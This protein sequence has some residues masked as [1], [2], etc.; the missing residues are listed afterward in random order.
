MDQGEVRRAIFNIYGADECRLRVD[1]LASGRV[2][3]RLRTGRGTHDWTCETLEEL[4]W[5]A[6][7]ADLP[8]DL[9]EQLRWELDLMGLR[10]M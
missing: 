10:G 3:L 9:S 2:R 1:I 5:L 7:E 8:A 6:L 4:P